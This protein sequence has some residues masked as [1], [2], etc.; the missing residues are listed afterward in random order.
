MTVVE[1][2]RVDSRRL[3]LIDSEFLSVYCEHL[4]D[5]LVRAVACSYPNLVWCLDVLARGSV[6]EN[7]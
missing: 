4:D 6:D 5:S 3:L 2:A 7:V 1:L